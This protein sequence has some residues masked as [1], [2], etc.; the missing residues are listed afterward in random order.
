[1]I[2]GLILIVQ[3]AGAIFAVIKATIMLLPAVAAHDAGEV[4]SAYKKI[5]TLAAVLVLILLLRPL[6][7]ILGNILGFD[8]SCII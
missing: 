5:V 2:K 4:N 6:V 1:M 3:M 7:K 8:I